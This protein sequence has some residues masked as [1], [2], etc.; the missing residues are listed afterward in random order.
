MDIDLKKEIMGNLVLAGS[1]S[2]LKN[3]QEHLMKFVMNCL[4]LNGLKPKLACAS[5]NVERRHASSIGG[6]VVG[7]LCVF[8][9][10]WMSY[11][12]YNEMGEGWI[13]RKMK[14]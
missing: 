2:I 9:K 3:M 12:E 5:Q 4:N 14:F 10:E 8:Q 13:E 11:E 1:H 7:N 6:S